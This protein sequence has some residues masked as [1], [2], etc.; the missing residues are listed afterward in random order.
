VDRV[1]AVWVDNLA[2]LLPARFDDYITAAG[3]V[4]EGP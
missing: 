4:V 3:F 1:T 2:A